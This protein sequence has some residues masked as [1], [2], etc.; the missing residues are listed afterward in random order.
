[1][2]QRIITPAERYAGLK[3]WIRENG[4]RKILLVCDGAFLRWKT[5]RGFF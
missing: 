2:E 3:D 5:L 1:M 4:C